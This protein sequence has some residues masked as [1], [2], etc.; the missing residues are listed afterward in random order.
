MPVI[1]G[2]AGMAKLGRFDMLLALLITFLACFG[3]GT[4]YSR[5][6]HEA[7]YGRSPIN[8]VVNRRRR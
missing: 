8:S 4:A 6:K 7:K 5:A 1:L 2:A 3:A